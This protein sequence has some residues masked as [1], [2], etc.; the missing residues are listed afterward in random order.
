MSLYDHLPHPRLQ[1]L[2]LAR[3]TKVNDQLPTHSAFAR[4][5]AAL[6]VK[7]TAAVGTMIC[8][9]VFTGI[10]LISLPSS[11]KS[12][13]LIIIVSWVA[14]T[15]L[16]LVLL[17]IIIVGQNIQ[18]AASD[19]RAEDTY[20]DAEAVLVEAQHIQQ[21]LEAQDAAI[22]AILKHLAA[23]PGGSVYPPEPGPVHAE[24]DPTSLIVPP[25]PG[26]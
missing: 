10:A 2:R 3:P 16:Q 25:E 15:F 23:L 11:L 6:A 22:E 18:S 24:H 8:A 12:K 9:Y 26:P 19:K 20:K 7:I 14:Q 13:N 5:N 1:E 4:F 21:H 17:S